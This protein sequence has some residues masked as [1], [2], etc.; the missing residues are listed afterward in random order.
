MTTITIR[1]A[2]VASLAVT[3]AGC[4]TPTVELAKG[5][6]PAGNEAATTLRRAVL[7][8]LVLE[9]GLNLIDRAPTGERLVARVLGDEIREWQVFDSSGGTVALQQKK[10]GDDDPDPDYCSMCQSGGGT[11]TSLPGQLR[12]CWADWGCQVCDGKAKNCKMECQTLA[13][14]E[15]QSSKTGGGNA[16]DDGDVATVLPDRSTA[17]FDA[18]TSRWSLTT[19]AGARIRI[20]RAASG[21]GCAVCTARPNGNTCWSVPCLPAK[22]S[23]YRPAL[24]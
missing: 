10:D 22:T 23:L 13:C 9:E 1:V 5:T 6:T 14:K 11:C 18:S 3:V 17:F 16:P 4:G 24:P 20:P 8:G 21:D 15:A 19:P 12:C 7:H 2:I